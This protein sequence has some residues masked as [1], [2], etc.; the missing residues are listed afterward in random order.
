MGSRWFFLQTPPV[1]F[2]SR[3]TD[4]QFRMKI[5]RLNKG[6]RFASHSGHYHNAIWIVAGHFSFSLLFPHANKTISYF[7]HLA[8][9]LL[10]LLL[11]HPL[12]KC[13]NAYTERHQWEC[14]CGACL[15]VF[16]PCCIGYVNVA[17]LSLPTAEKW[18]Q[19][20][21]LYK[22]HCGIRSA[23]EGKNEIYIYAMSYYNAKYCTRFHNAKQRKYL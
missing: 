19:S 16:S 21:N 13:I 1:F 6:Q 4:N 18:W 17:C 3:C 20:C 14:C 5:Y 2:G 12:A 10:S 8:K 9:K 22:W 23:M 15:T 7:P 11:L